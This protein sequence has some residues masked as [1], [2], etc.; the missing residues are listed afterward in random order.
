MM[1]LPARA[2]FCVLA[3]TAMI[4]CSRYSRSTGGTSEAERQP[5]WDF[6]SPQIDRQPQGISVTLRS[7]IERANWCRTADRQARTTGALTTSQ[8]NGSFTAPG[9]QQTASTLAIHCSSDQKLE[10]RLVI[11]DATGVASDLEVPPQAVIL[12]TFDLNHDSASELLLGETMGQRNDSVR[13][14]QLVALSKGNL[15]TIEDFG[16]VYEDPCERDS[17]ATMTALV[18][19]YLPLGHEVMPKFSAEVYRAPCVPPG[20]QPDWKRVGR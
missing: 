3:C 15:K 4:A 13:T 16:Q 9:V 5:L 1:S 14:A 20:T 12:A 2:L 19:N 18:I 6:R 8:A 17:K 7:Y 11:S 10:T